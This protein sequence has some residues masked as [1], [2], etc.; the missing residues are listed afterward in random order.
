MTGDGVGDATLPEGGDWRHPSLGLF[1]RCGRPSAMSRRPWLST[2][3]HTAMMQCVGIDE[4]AVGSKTR[5]VPILDMRPFH[6]VAAL[7]GALALTSS[8]DTGGN[9][10]SMDVSSTW[11]STPRSP[12]TTCGL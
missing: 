5:V 4:I 3:D 9:S 8:L 12:P 2:Q 11:L 10:A 1:L 7:I 6:F